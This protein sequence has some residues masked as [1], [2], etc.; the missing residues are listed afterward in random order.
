MKKIIYSSLS[1]LI[2]LTTL[3]FTSCT[4]EALSV[5]YTI[6]DKEV[7]LPSNPFQAYYS[8]S[9]DINKSDVIAIIDA[10]DGATIENVSSAA[11]KEGLKIEVSSSG[12]TLNQIANIELYMKDKGTSG[13][14][15]QIA[16]SSP[17]SNNATEV[18]MVSNGIDLKSLT[19][20]DKTITIKVLNS[21]GGNDPI[22]IK[23]TNG[24]VNF[25]VKQ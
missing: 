14:G 8:N 24:V 22:C 25:S 1:V 15:T 16:Y 18:T 17:I 9:F 7:C 13:D 6:D 3:T 4:K 11:L 10:F 20:S 5:P 19:T 2:L 12:T 21:T 23:L